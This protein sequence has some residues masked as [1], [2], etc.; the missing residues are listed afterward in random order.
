MSLAQVPNIVKPQSRTR[1]A[2]LGG[3]L[4]VSQPA[5]GFRAGLDSVLLGAAVARSEGPLLDLGAGAGVAGLVA[6]SN[7]PGL[8]G[9]L[10][11]VNPELA[12]LARA[13]IA[14]NGF[15]DRADVLTLDVTAAGVA[16]AAAGLLTDH[17]AAVI[18]NPPFFDAPAGTAPADA[19][20]ARARHMA[21]EALDLWIRTAAASA[22]PG[23]EVIFIHRVEALPGL[24]AGFDLRFG[25]LT[26]L[27][28]APRPGAPVSRVLVRAVKGSRAPLVMAETR[29]LHQAEG[30][31][32]TPPIAALLAGETGL[33]W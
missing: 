22:A 12:A 18:A 23:G 3:R 33:V 15:A 7:N 27:P 8:S 24:L 1:D 29:Y 14:A 31:P 10:V 21:P 13:N 20:R 30:H 6:L 16:R 11:E 19:Q 2:F 17:F 5:T 26:I 28:F 32:F 9:V 25:A 4:Q